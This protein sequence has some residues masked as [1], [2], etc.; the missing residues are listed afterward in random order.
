MNHF[1]LFALGFVI[2]VLGYPSREILFMG[3]GVIL[4]SFILDYWTYARR[5]SLG[6]KGPG[7]MVEKSSPYASPKPQPSRS[8]G[9]ELKKK[10]EG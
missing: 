6:G 3:G 2:M 8:I 9:L 10:V 7:E 1:L 4:G 5:A